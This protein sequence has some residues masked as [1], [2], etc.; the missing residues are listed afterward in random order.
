MFLATIP[1]VIY[2]DKIGRKPV[3]ISGAILM[4]LCHIIVGILTACFSSNWKAHVAAGWVAC[5]LVW[6]F[7]IAFGYSWGPC[8]WIIISEIFP[9]SARGKGMSVAASSNW[10]RSFSFLVVGYIHII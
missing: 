3:L 5:A 10:V 2:I 8:A 9:L 7:A 4:A 1:A 6:V